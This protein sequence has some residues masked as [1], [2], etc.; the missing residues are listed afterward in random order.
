MGALTAA[1]PQ[2]SAVHDVALRARS[3]LSC[4]RVAVLAQ[5]AIRQ[6]HGRAA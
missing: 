6:R 5:R 1:Y 2:D 4:A 3:L